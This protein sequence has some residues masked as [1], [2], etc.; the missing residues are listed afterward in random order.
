V[1]GLALAVAFG[2]TGCS[3]ASRDSGFEDVRRLAADR[4][5]MRIEWDRGSAEDRAADEAVGALLAR[6]LDADSAVQ[7]ALLNNRDLQATFEDLSVAQS[8]LVAAGMLRNPVFDASVRFAEAGGGTGVELSVVQDFLDVLV[9]PLRRRAAGAAFEAAK[10][11]VAGAVLGL[12]GETRRAFY[13]VQAARQRLEV[14]QTAALAADASYDYARRLHAAGNVND[15]DLSNEQAAYEQSRLDLAAAEADAQQARERLN[16]LMGAWGRR[17]QWTVAQRLPDVPGPEDAVPQDGLERR[18]VERSLD[19][20]A[21]R[22]GVEVAAGRLGLARPLGVFEGAGVGA[23]AERETEGGWSAGPA[24][25]LPIPL[26]NQGQPAS[27]AAAAELRRARQR[28]AALAVEVRSR[29]RAAWSR[30]DAARARAAYYQKVILPLRER[31]VDQTQRQ[32]NAMQV[33]PFQLL[34]AKQQQVEAG[35]QYV[36]ALLEYWTARADLDLIL[37]GKLPDHAGASAAPPR[38][39]MLS[40]GAQH[41]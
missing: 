2:A 3:N 21:A 5:H 17:T 34:N 13:S 30:V 10:L 40:T 25:S 18:A 7:V 31:I 8:D 19:L 38:M 15:L 1:L 11:R 23:A 12:A 20:A 41:D 35:G 26:F 24:F 29:A 39:R 27:S 6:D 14:R 36:D 16:V 33:S 22:Q 9:I 32:F 28:Y 4:T 37:E